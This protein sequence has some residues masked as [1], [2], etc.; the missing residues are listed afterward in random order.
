MRCWTRYMLLVPV[1]AIVQALSSCSTIDGPED[2]GK[3]PVEASLAFT[4]SSA[5]G[6]TTRMDN[7]VVQVEG[8]QFRGMKSLLVIPFTTNGE[9]V[10]AEDM[11]LI[12]TV[13]GND[14]NKVANNQYYYFDKCYMSRGTNYVLV[15][16]QAAD[17]TGKTASNL[18]GKLETNL[19]DRML[20]ND[21][22]FSLSS[23]RSTTAVDFKAQDLANYLTTIANTTGWSTT[24]NEQ[25]KALYLDFINAQSEGN[26]LMAGSAAHVKAYVAALKTQLTTIKNAEGTATEIVTLCT[27][28]IAKIDN[29]NSIDNNTY[30]ASI[31]L[32]DGA[33]ALRWSNGV[34][35]V[36]TT[37]T[38][39][40]NI[41]N[42]TRWTYPA[43]LRYYANSGIQT[44]KQDVTKPN[45]E[46][47]SSWSS[48]LTNYYKAGNAVT[49]ET[50]SVAVKDPLHYGV[51][52][53]QMTLNKITGTLKDAKDQTVNYQ[54]ASKFPLKAVIIG[55]Q[56]SVGFDFKPKEPQS[57][58][59][60]RFIY[61]TVVGSAN[62][63]TG[64]Y[65][66]NT[67]V[68][69]TYDGEKVPIILEFENK[70]GSAFHG[71]DGIIYPDTK[72]YLIAQIDP[73]NGASS[74]SLAQGRVFTCDFITQM[75]LS[76]ISLA[77]AYS[78][79]PDL[80]APRLEI[81]VQVTTTWIQPT[82]T[83]VIL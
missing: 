56:H 2:D 6:A 12:S 9:P 60:A 17:I 48:L 25:M 79:M 77:N 34:F 75:T 63:T 47:Q 37:T 65:T 74:N 81:G 45:Y 83:T 51:A 15:Y 64:N 61:D 42:I 7:D 44:S 73:A 76:V 26:G 55:A 32:P 14:N 24:S 46:G 80:L 50:K 3:S 38:T 30:P 10:K 11:P 78:C 33:A 62:A 20:P 49:G 68:L 72:F 43:E 4:V 23:I 19:V 8:Q 52:C 16:G 21:I 57:D 67:L 35:K 41:N 70:T 69:Q 40:D 13:S 29:N 31:D 28:I 66:V 27:D 5:A 82:T 1:L 71:K 18:N 58:V 22:T 36:C 59:D 39:L 54:D 53:L